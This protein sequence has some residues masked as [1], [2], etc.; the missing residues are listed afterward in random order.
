[1]SFHEEQF[2]QL[3]QEERAKLTKLENEFDRM[4]DESKAVGIKILGSDS[5]WITK[6]GSRIAIEDM[7]KRHLENTIKFLK[8]RI[9][10]EHYTMQWKA[11]IRVMEKEL[12]KRK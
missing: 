11:Y 6:K 5:I 8:A 12:K 10:I 3:C 9:E 2:K 1:M 4:C 7:S